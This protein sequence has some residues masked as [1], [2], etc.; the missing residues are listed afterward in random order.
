VHL[1]GAATAPRAASRALA[2]WRV[3]VVCVTVATALAALSLLLPWATTYDPWA[4]IVWGREVAHLDL[5]T[6][7][8]PSWKPLPVLLTTAFSAAGGAAPALWLVVARAGGLLAIAAA[9][10]AGRRLAGPVAAVTAATALLLDVPFDR[11]VWLGDSEGL[12]V[13]AVLAGVERHCAGARR[14]AFAL[15]AVA[16]LLRPEV[17]PFLALYGAWLGWREPG[18]R[19]L[20]VGSSIA[21]AVLWFGP[22]LWG[23]G[24][25]WRSAE[26]AQEPAGGAATFARDPA[27]EVIRRARVMLVGPVKAAALAGLLFA[28][29]RWRTRT[30]QTAL[31][32]GA[33]AAVWLAMVAVM[34]SHGF[35]GNER[36]VMAPMAIVC[37]LAGVGVAS[38]ARVGLR[39]MRR[40]RLAARG[41]AVGG[42]V[43]L[44]AGIVPY[45]SAT[46]EALGRQLATLEYQ[47]ELRTGM[48]QAVALAGGAARVRACGLPVTENYSVPMLAWDL[49]V[50]IASVGLD[51]APRGVVFQARPTPLSPRDP[52]LRR[53]RNA[54][55]FVVA[56]GPV[57]V[58]ERC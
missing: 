46:S 22:E 23:S 24:Q 17:W 55:R 14:T 33:G 4:W 12:L 28:V 3:A 16:A 6:T 56:A 27:L 11:V 15:G 21:I 37:T 36:Y 31:A 45:V 34:T 51:P 5:Q 43:L 30:A 58:F 41:V 39:L 35:S 13:A 18:A 42:V 2:P 32:L 8:G 50:H 19:R 9:Y 54:P 53:G 52:R 44:A 25:L 47:A 38:G 57:R 29:V 1:T 20:V 40:P 26:R 10:V 48:S 49:V 7:A